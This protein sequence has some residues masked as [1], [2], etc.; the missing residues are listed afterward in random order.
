MV[1]LVPSV[2]FWSLSGDRGLLLAL[3]AQLAFGYISQ[4]PLVRVPDRL[5]SVEAAEKVP[6]LASC[7]VHVWMRSGRPFDRVFSGLWCCC[8]VSVI[9]VAEV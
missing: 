8:L 6:S 9:S 4:S 5:W 3:L 2:W 1:V 7:P